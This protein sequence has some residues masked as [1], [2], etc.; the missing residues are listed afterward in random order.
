MSGRLVPEDPL[1]A[2]I[3]PTPPED[4]GTDEGDA[5]EPK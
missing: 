3:P 1:T 4:V 5:G 2:T